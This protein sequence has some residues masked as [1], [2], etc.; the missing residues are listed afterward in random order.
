[1]DYQ[2]TV[3][4]GNKILTRDAQKWKHLKVR[5][6]PS[7]TNHRINNNNTVIEEENWFEEPTNCSNHTPK[8]HQ[9]SNEMEQARALGNDHQNI[10]KM[11][12][13]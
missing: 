3:Q 8:G 4:R 13:P 10:N 11:L 5:C 12:N 7:Y 6:K 9:W 1:M 2:T